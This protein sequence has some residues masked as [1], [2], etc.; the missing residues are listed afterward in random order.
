VPQVEEYSA[1]KHRNSTPLT[2]DDDYND[3]FFE[4]PKPP[5]RK[6][7]HRKPPAVDLSAT[8]KPQANQNPYPV[9][10]GSMDDS[11][12]ERSASRHSGSGGSTGSS[13]AKISLK[14][15]EL[16][17]SETAQQLRSKDWEEQQTAVSRI[18]TILKQ[19]PEELTPFVQQIFQNLQDTVQ[20]PLT[21]LANTALQLS[22]DIFEKFSVQ[23]A[24][25]ALQW[26]N[27]CFTIVCS[28]NQFIAD[29]AE[30]LLLI[31]SELSPRSRTFQALTVA[32]KHKNPI[33]CWK[34]VTC[35]PI[36]IDYGP[37]SD[38]EFRELLKAIV[39]LLR[40][41]RAETRE[42]VKITIRKLSSD[43]RFQQSILN[44][45]ASPQDIAELKK[46]SLTCLYR[47]IYKKNLQII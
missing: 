6:P 18:S 8:M 20:S 23:L 9:T 29:G 31:I 30:K 36:I 38:K 33:A 34:V 43:E 12:V 32:T 41:A 25:Q 21:A 28:S 13:S 22:A 1:P 27:I 26:M 2:V 40:D 44:L 15:P 45:T 39:H 14:A 11:T 16:Q 19:S 42:A 37:L 35:L 10:S 47:Q 7:V 5:K 46:L 4:K 17:L 3:D 24:P